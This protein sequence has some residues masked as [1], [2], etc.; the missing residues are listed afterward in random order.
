MGFGVSVVVPAYNVE[1]YI[2]E[3]L[4]SLLAQDVPNLQIICID[5]G[6]TDATRAIIEGYAKRNEAM[7]VLS[8]ENKG[9]SVARNEG[10]KNA[11]GKYLYFCDSDDK[12]VDGALR[13]LY[14]EAER[15]TADIV[16]FDAD[17]FFESESLKEAH[18]HYASFYHRK[19]NYDAPRTGKQMVADMASLG[20]WRPSIV[21]QFYRTEFLRENRL[22]FIP[23]I[24]HEDNA[25]SYCA[26]IKAQLVSHLGESLYRR[27]LRSHSIM[28]THESS[29]N[30]VGYFRCLIAM[31]K[32]SAEQGIEDPAVLEVPYSVLMLTRDVYQSLPPSEQEASLKAFSDI[33][34]ILF[35]I[36]IVKDGAALDEA[37]SARDELNAIK[38]S[39]RFK[40]AERMADIRNMLPR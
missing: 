23:D 24:L 18:G 25:F 35:W 5:D 15:S 14:E 7:M 28:T 8:H 26:A 38:G 37:A 29:R 10:M 33:E 36:C 31:A 27:R 19:G 12:L 16:Y 4:E 21:L 20:D 22:A 6:S 30:A 34:R 1:S 32:A 40:L 13:K 17:S 2:G 39:R 9:Q 3:C 11:T